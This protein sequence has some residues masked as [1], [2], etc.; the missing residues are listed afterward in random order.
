MI[1]VNRQNLSE[2]IEELAGMAA[3]RLSI[4]QSRQQGISWSK[5]RQASLKAQADAKLK[6]LVQETLYEGKEPN[7]VVRIVV[8][9]IKGKS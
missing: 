6:S 1:A 5:A 2:T 9:K 4:M 7:E 8:E 3:R